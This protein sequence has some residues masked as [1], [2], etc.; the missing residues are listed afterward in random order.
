[1]N[2]MN[3][4]QFFDLAM[5]VIARQ[6]TDAERAELD[7]LL[8]REPQR[9]AEFAQLQAYVRVAKGALPLVD[10]TQA[11][12]GELPAYARGRLQTK[13]RQTLGRP[14]A[15]GESQSAKERSAMWTWRW[16][17]GLA[18]AT[19]VIVLVALPA[20]RGTS[21]PVIQVAMLNGAGVVRGASDDATALFKQAWEKAEVHS[22]ANADDLQEWEGEAGQEATVKVIYDQSTGEIHVLGRWNGKTLDKTFLVEADLAATLEK[23]KA[24]IAEQ[25]QK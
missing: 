17:L 14:E 18:A 1:M 5:K 16:V 2:S 15:A 20:F 25:T 21:E 19:A 9:S 7:A 6:C 22:F 8:A 10:A 4:E 12:A 24:F 11:T 23:A 13:V 3:D